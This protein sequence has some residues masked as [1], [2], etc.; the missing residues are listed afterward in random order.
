ME[1]STSIK[2]AV[3]GGAIAGAISGLFAGLL[4]FCVLLGTLSGISLVRTL[5]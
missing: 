3:V 2:I 1:F 4:A 5:F